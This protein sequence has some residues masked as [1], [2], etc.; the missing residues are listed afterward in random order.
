[1]NPCSTFNYLCNSN[2]N[3][4]WLIQWFVLILS[5]WMCSVVTHTGILNNA[6]FFLL[7]KLHLAHFKC[8]KK[9]CTAVVNAT[10][11]Q[12][13]SCVHYIQYVIMLGAVS[14]VACVFWPKCF[15]KCDVK[16]ETYKKFIKNIFSERM[17]CEQLANFHP[18]FCLY[19]AI[20]PNE[21]YFS[22]S[23]QFGLNPNTTYPEKNTSTQYIYGKYLQ[24]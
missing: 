4:N 12:Y 6:L 20:Q 16:R 8:R 24:L 23:E 11:R 18:K 7:C 15:W 1:M 10:L 14:K 19:L 3:D 5:Q 21:N 9:V 13:R 17:S 22:L 2:S